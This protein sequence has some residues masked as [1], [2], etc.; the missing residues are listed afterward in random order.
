MNRLLSAYDSC[1]MSDNSCSQPAKHGQDAIL[2]LASSQ[3]LCQTIMDKYYNN[4]WLTFITKLWFSNREILLLSRM[5]I[6][7]SW[8]IPS[9]TR[10]RFNPEQSTRSF[11]LFLLLAT[12]EHLHLIV[13][14]VWGL[15]EQTVWGL[16]M[17]LPSWFLTNDLTD[18]PPTWAPLYT[19]RIAIK[20]KLTILKNVRFKLVCSFLMFF[21]ILKIQITF[22]RS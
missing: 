19:I 17:S 13:E 9:G 20:W 16:E 22:I 7:V 10:V 21:F 2:N 4:G 1:E 3:N 6:V 5:S 12:W 15:F 8:G 11:L 14:S 18:I